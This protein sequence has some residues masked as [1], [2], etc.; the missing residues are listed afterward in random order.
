MD[1]HPTNTCFDDALDYMVEIAKSHPAALIFEDIRLVHGICL[2]PDGRPYAHAWVE[3]QHTGSAFFF[4]IL[5]GKRV[6]VEV[7]AAEYRKELKVQKFTEYTYE[8][9]WRENEK[10]VNYGPWIEEYRELCLN[11]KSAD[12]CT[13]GL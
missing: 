4:G 13:R 11:G 5:K 1:I 7:D 10:H 2:M 8:Q 6:R 3:S 9:A 12:V